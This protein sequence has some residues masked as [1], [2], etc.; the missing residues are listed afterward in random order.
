MKKDKPAKPAPKPTPVM[1]PSE[2]RKHRDYGKK[3]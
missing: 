3:R 2:G 1:Q